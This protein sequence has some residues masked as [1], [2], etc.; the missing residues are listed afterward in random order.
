MSSA[1]GRITPQ[2]G[3]GSVQLGRRMTPTS[4]KRERGALS[5]HATAGCSVVV[6][7]TNGNDYRKAQRRNRMQ[8]YVH[9]ES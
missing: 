7:E 1:V 6:P 9:T 5:W 2:N 4:R 8:S 3:S